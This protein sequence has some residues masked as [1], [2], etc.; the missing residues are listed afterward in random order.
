MKPSKRA[1]LLVA[2]D[3]PD[4]RLLMQKAFATLDSEHEL[5]VVD[6][7][8]ALMD[9][10]HRRGSYTAREQAPRPDLILLD[11]NMPRKSG[12]E[13]LAEIR[14]T[15]ELRDIPIVVLT[16]APASADCETS[17]KLGANG[18]LVKPVTFKLYVELLTTV[19]AYWLSINQRPP[20]KSGGSHGARA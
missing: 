8:E 16:T 9:Y 18:Y 2:E 10:L 11:L 19:T 7:G 1:I 13:A 17:Y 3:D 20:S 14:T 4:D 5:R 15:P 6:D 12:H